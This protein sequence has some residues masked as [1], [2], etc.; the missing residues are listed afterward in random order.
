MAEPRDGL[1]VWITWLSKVMSGDQSC[2]WASWF[3]THFKGYEKVPS[4]FDLAKWTVDHSRRVHELHAERRSAGE[5]VFLEGENE[6]RYEWQGGLVVAGKPDLVAVSDS[7]TTVY[8]VKTGKERRA[9][10]IQVMLYMYLLPL[11]TR[12]YASTRPSGCV[13]YGERRSPI[14][15]EAIDKSFINNFNYFL[16]TIAS[17][18]PAVKVASRH[19]CR[20]CDIAKSE[21]PE[22][23]EQ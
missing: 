23:M 8:D 19:E 9:D 10:H 14:P 20:F 5:Q 21:C 2:V 15:A 1:Y 11:G 4:D 22:R 3:K 17:N 13:V 12:R 6:I 16:G 18:T 7:G